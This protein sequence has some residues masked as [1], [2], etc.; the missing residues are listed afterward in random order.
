MIPSG[1][2]QGMLSE[3]DGEF[4]FKKEKKKKKK[5]PQR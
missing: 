5:G 2:G 1:Y 4:V 3:Y